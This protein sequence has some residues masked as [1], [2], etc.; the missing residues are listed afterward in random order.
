MFIN[1]SY[2]YNGFLIDTKILLTSTIT[3]GLE[4]VEDANPKKGYINQKTDL[5]VQFSICGAL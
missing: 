3:G 2:F 1:E 5:I 4:I